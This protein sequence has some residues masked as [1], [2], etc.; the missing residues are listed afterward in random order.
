M[1]YITNFLFKLGLVSGATPATVLVAQAGGIFTIATVASIVTDRGLKLT[2]GVSRW[3]PTAG[4]LLTLA[5]TCL[6]HGLS[7]GEASIVVPIA[8]FGFV[9]AAIIG[10][11]FFKEAITKR[12]ILGLLCASGAVL[13]LAVA[14]RQSLDG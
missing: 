11:V 14:A 13:L 8:Q 6:L 2:P 10:F 5:F 12:K 3:G 4:I 1:A 9:V 7:L